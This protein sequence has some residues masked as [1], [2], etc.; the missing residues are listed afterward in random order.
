MKK[1]ETASFVVRFNQKIFATKS[2]EPKM[3]WR[4]NIRHVQ[5][6]DEKRFAKFEVVTQFIQEK[7]QEMAMEAMKDKTPEEQKGIL[8]QSFDI[9][10]KVA[11]VTPKAIIDTIKDP[12]KQLAEFQNQI[13]N[14][15][16]NINL[17]VEEVIEQRKSELDDWRITSKSDYKNIMERLEE[18]TRELA[19]LNKKVDKMSK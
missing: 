2:G 19:A 9:W 6:G 1:E 15:N 18:V 4:G 8:A 3:Q 10:K 17:R 11:E 13:S 14:I 12:K 7:L 5:T 16:E